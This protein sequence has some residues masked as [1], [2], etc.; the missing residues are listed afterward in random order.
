MTNLEYYDTIFT[1]HEMHV[2]RLS[3]VRRKRCTPHN[4]TRISTLAT[5]RL[6]KRVALTAFLFARPHTPLRTQ[7]T[8][9]HHV[10]VVANCGHG[11]DMTHSKHEACV[12]RPSAVMANG[13]S[14]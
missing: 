13:F 12:R 6:V 14:A 10:P 4:R 8:N 3:D 9:D 5:H 11:H 1:D 2:R 7:I